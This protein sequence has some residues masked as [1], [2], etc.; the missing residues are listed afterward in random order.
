ME[1]F[2]CGAK[3]IAG[4]GAVKALEMWRG[5]RIL[6]VTDSLH[7]ADGM[8]DWVIHA[9]GASEWEI[10]DRVSPQ[11]TAELVS[12][13]AARLR[14]MRPGAVVAL[15][16]GDVIDLA[17]AMVSFSGRNIRLAAV[18]TVLGTGAEVTGAVTL[19]HGTQYRRIEKDSLLPYLAVLD[20]ELLAS[21][22]MQLAA[23]GG[24]AAICRAVEGYI[25]RDAGF[26]A[27]ALAKES[28]S[29]LLAELPRFQEG[30]QTRQ[31]LLSASAM[32]AVAVRRTGGLCGCLTESLHRFFPVSRGRLCAILLPPVLELNAYAP[33]DECGG[34]ARSAGVGGSGLM[35]RQR[36]IRLRRELKLPENLHQAGVEPEKLWSRTGEIVAE[37]LSAPEKSQN[38][39]T[40]E[41]FMVRRILEQVM[42]R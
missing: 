32:S 24:F 14:E 26:F 1:T 15:G 40:V 34:L 25:A 30:N 22:P 3:L 38:P 17:K 12:A 7:A 39:M 35:L 16:D 23:E 41:D 27:Q 42:G 11:P 18:P 33:G 21:L 19:L 37:V 31:R 20:G 6:V 29:V 28:L 4:C 2:D 9:A 5:E 8:A 13:G 36:L 10:F